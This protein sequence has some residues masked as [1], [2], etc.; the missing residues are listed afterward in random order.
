[1]GLSAHLRGFDNHPSRL[2]DS[3]ALLSRR[4]MARRFFRSAWMGY[5]QGNGLVAATAADIRKAA[6][7]SGLDPQLMR[8]AL[9]QESAFNGALRACDLESHV[10][11]QLSEKVCS[12][13]LVEAVRGLRSILSGMIRN[14][15]GRVLHCRDLKA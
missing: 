2:V 9:E 4:L 10:A 5:R 11:R 7:L 15:F 8:F 13:P 1:M 6:A 12:Q 14:E 3:A